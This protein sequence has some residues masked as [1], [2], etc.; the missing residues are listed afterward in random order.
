MFTVY[1][2]DQKGQTGNLVTF[3][4]TCNISLEYYF[5]KNHNIALHRLLSFPFF[6][7][8]RTESTSSYLYH[9]SR[10]WLQQ[11]LFFTKVIV[12]GF[13]FGFCFCF[14]LF[15]CCFFFNNTWVVSSAAELMLSNYR[16][17]LWI[18]CL[19]TS[20]KTPL[21]YCFDNALALL[22]KTLNISL[23]PCVQ[24]YN[25]SRVLCHAS[26]QVMLC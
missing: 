8:I 14:V 16:V 19:E 10:N 13:F 18:F 11:T 5:Q 2:Y 9:I 17:S 22:I 6:I 12:R 24:C 3:H 7:L 23:F 20:Q 4:N 21:S 15:V 1:C 25:T 26:C